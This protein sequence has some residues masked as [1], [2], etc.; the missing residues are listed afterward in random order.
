M[1]S[2]NRDVT[3]K[4]LSAKSHHLVY[5]SPFCLARSLK[6]PKVSLIYHPLNK[7]GTNIIAPPLGIHRLEVKVY[8]TAYS[9]LPSSSIVGMEK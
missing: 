2:K 5:K 1:A 4:Y 3:M 6:L 7:K 8:E 9:V